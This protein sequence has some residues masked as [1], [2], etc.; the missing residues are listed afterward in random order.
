MIKL[1]QLNVEGDR[2]IDKIT[3]FL[4]TEKPDVLCLQEVSEVSFNLFKAELGM[5]GLFAPM[6]TNSEGI[7]G[8]GVLSQLSII[9]SKADYYWRGVDHL[10]GSKMHPLDVYWSVFALVRVDVVSGDDVFTVTTTHFPKNHVGNEVSDF[11]KELQVDLTKML[12]S[13]PELIFTGDTNCPRGT[14]IFDNWATMYKDNIPKEVVTSLDENLHRAGYL[15]YMVDALFTTPHYEV[16][17]IKL[18]DGVSDHLAVVASIKK[19]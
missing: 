10:P 8:A 2:H 11:Q 5:T 14:D 13:M 12:N 6:L 3:P 9:T 7:L 17:D 4:K 15:P 16:V 18:V 19:I 1:I